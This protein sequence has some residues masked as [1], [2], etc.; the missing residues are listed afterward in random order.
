MQNYITHLDTSKLVR[1]LVLFLNH[2][3]LIKA[4]DNCT[5]HLI[6]SQN[7]RER[8]IGI[9][10]VLDIEK[11]SKWSDFHVK[12]CTNFLKFYHIANFVKKCFNTT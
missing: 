1:L 10:S 12:A 8:Q 2:F 9:T 11:H 7:F 3:L 6:Q 4:R 5:C